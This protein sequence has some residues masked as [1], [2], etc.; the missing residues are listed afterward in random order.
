MLKYVFT[1]LLLLMLK[2]K[3]NNVKNSHDAVSRD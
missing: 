3:K 1:A 2:K